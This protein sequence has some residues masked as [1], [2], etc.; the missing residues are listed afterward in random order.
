MRFAP[1]RFAPMRFAPMRLRRFHS[2]PPPSPPKTRTAGAASSSPVGAVR[3][4]NLHEYQSKD[5]M[6][7]H[8]VIVQRGRM[9]DSPAS[10]AEVA[11]SILTANGKAEIILKA[12]IHAGGRGKGTFSNGFKGGVK[13]LATPTEVQTTAAKMLGYKLVTKQTAAEGQL[14]SKVLVNEGI[15]IDKEYYFAILMDRAHGGPVLVASTQG[16]MDIEEV[17]EKNPSAIIT[18][19]VDI[20]KGLGD[21]QAKALAVKLGFTGKLIDQAAHQFISLYKLF[22]ATDATQVRGGA[23]AKR[24]KAKRRKAKRPQARFSTLTRFQRR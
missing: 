21:K 9:A 2:P 17:A 12:Q 18:E 8:G 24:R 4:L 1:M 6:E 14:C 22:V 7:S 16:G 10:A 19:P 20:L 3:F 15:T 23:G 5:L 11:K 13:V